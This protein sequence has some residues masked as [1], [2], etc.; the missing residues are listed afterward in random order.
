MLTPFK[1][2]YAVTHALHMG[3][4]AQGAEVTSPLLLRWSWGSSYCSL[5]LAGLSYISP[6][7][8]Y[9]SSK[10]FSILSCLLQW[11]LLAMAE[12]KADF[13]LLG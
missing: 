1:Q 2:P 13:L 7:A 6:P 4:E 9:N 5:G 3:H 11:H 12:A 10:I 8:I